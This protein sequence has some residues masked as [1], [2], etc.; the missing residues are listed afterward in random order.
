MS[1]RLGGKQGTA[2]LGTN[3]DQPPNYAFANRR[4]NSKDINYSLGDFWLFLDDQELWVLMSLAGTITSEGSV[5]TWVQLTGGAG[6]LISLTGD[7]GGPVFVDA[8][9]N[10]NVV[11]GTNINT[12]GS[13]G[14]S[15]VTFN[16][17]D[18][19]VVESVSTATNAPTQ[20]LLISDNIIG[21]SGS[22]ANVDINLVPK[23]SGDV[24][25]NPGDLTITAGNINLTSANGAGTQGV[26]NFSGTKWFHNF[27]GNTFVGGDSGNFTTS[28]V[29]STALGNNTLQGLTTG[30][31]NCAL[32]GLSLSDLTTGNQN[33]A[34]GIFSLS[35]LVGGSSNCAF[36][37]DSG[38]NLLNGSHNILIGTD[39][40][41]Q[42]TG[43]ESSNIIISNQG[44]A[45]ESHVIRIGTSG[46]GASQQARCFIA[47]IRDVTTDINDAIPVLID[48]DGQL[49]TVSSSIRY[50]ENIQP[51]GDAS[52]R[53]YQLRPVTFSYKKDSSKSKVFGLIAEEVEKVMP[54]IVVFKNTIPETVKYHDL[55]MLLLNELQKLA[56]RVEELEQR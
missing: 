27:G 28:S 12:V 53:I 6:S 55:P 32:G 33:T 7:T 50:K 26:I 24:V 18:N 13:P 40:A 8:N 35:D 17:D 43:S 51:M 23:G 16:L 56:K 36:G 25:I 15:T 4:P 29:D 11:G 1:N 31:E 37:N 47:A 41:G 2:Y 14:I 34:A 9:A 44:V 52:S 19:I 3:A 39:C 21:A 54:E 5:A 46:V 48:S 30:A 38:T 10:I 49:G 42:Y 45:G 22:D 20:N